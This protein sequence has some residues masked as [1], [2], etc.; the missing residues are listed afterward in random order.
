DVDTVQIDDRVNRIERASLPDLYLLADRVSY[1]GDEGGRHLSAV[2]FLQMTL[3]LPHAQAP[4]I[5]RDDLLIKARPAG[6]V[7][8][9]QLR[10]ERA[11]AITRNI[12]GQLAELAL[13]RLGA[14]AVTGVAGGVGDRLAL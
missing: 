14:V 11:L 1:S 10:F 3:N 2:H 6:L 13:Q 8:L 5:E 9:H 7:T 12:E 4:C